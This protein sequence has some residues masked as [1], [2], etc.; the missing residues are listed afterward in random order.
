MNTTS[1][2]LVRSVKVSYI[3]LRAIVVSVWDESFSTAGHIVL[4]FAIVAKTAL[5]VHL[6]FVYC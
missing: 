1:V 5:V 6:Y 4:S 3:P 2:H